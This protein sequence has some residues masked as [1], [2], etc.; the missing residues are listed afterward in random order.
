MAGSPTRGTSAGEQI[1]KHGDRPEQEPDP[2]PDAAPPLGNVT[3]ERA[4]EEPPEQQVDGENGE[5][6][7]HDHHM[8][9]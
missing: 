1:Q 9:S 6:Q 7:A 8:M 3:V 5:Q 2:E 4:D